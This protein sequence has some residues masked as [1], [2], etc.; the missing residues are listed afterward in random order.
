[1]AEE[2]EFPGR[3]INLSGGSQDI[4]V[5]TPVG[6]GSDNGGSAKL[7]SD[8]L[9]AG[10]QTANSGLPN[11]SAASIPKGGRYDFYM[12]GRDMEEMYG[13]QQGSWQ[14]WGN[15]FGKMVGTATTSFLNG[16]V[17][18]VYG[19]GSMI[20][21]QRAASFYDNEFNR[22]LDAT[23]QELENYLPNFYTQAERDASWY[24]P[25]N[26]LT[27]NFFSDKVLK[28]LGYSIGSIGAGF[29]WGGIL[30]SIGL[31]NRLVQAG[32]GLETVEAVENAILTAPKIG[33]YGAVSN[34]LTGLSNQYLKPLASS[35]LTNADRG[36]TSA[37]GTMGE[38]SFESLQNLNAARDKMI[39]SYINKYG[40]AP[41]GDALNEINDYAEKVGNFTWGMNVALLTATNYIQLP[42][43]LN[44]SKVAERRAMNEITKDAIAEGATIGERVAVKYKKAAGVLES[45]AGNPGRLFNKYVAKP[46]GLF[47][48]PSEAFEEGAQFAIQ[49]GTDS[50]FSRAYD[51]NQDVSSFWENVAGAFQ[52]VLGEGVTKTLTTKEGLEGIL[53]GGLSGGLQTSFSPFGENT[54]KE[55]GFFGEGGFK[56][57]NTETALKAIN[58]SKNLNDVLKDGVKYANIAINSQKLRQEAIANNDTLNEK[59]YEQDYTLAY[60]MPRVKYGKLDSIKEEVGLYKQQALTE[61]GFQ[62][63]QNEGVVLQGETREQ[64]LQRIDN[65]SQ[66]ASQTNKMFEM[67]DDK[68]SVLVDKDGERLYGDDLIEKMTYA[69]AKIVNY[70]Q[71]TSELQGKLAGEGIFTST[72]DDALSNN[73]EWKAGDLKG[74]LNNKDVQ[75][76][77]LK[78]ASQVDTSESITKDEATEDLGDYI[79][80][81]IRRKDFLEEFNRMKSNPEEF[82][83]IEPI[84]TTPTPGEEKETITV[85]TQDGEE[86]IEIGT[87]YF[88]GRVVKKTDKDKD[89]YEAPKFTVLGEN[90]DG[91]IQIKTEKGIHNVSKERFASYKLGKV[92]DTLANRKAK[93]FLDHWNV[94]YQFNFG[95]DKGGKVNGRLKYSPKEGVLLFTYKNKKG[96]TKSIEVTG[97][98][99]VAKGNFKKPMIT[100]VMKL[101]AAQQKSLE[102]FAAEKDDRL[103][104]KR[105]ARL[106]VLNDLFEELSSSQKNTTALI[107]KKQEEIAKIKKELASLEEEIANA[108]IDKRAKNTVRFKSATKK[109]LQSA[110][111]LSRMQD[112]L[113]NEVLKLQSDQEEIEFNLEYVADLAQN[114]DLMPTDSA[115]FLEE[116]NDQVIDLE[117]LQEKTGKQITIVT[118][119]LKETEKALNSAIDFITNLIEKFENKYPDVPRAMGQDFVDFLKTNPNF[120]KLKPYYREELSELEDLIANVEEGDITVNESKLQEL[121]DH[122]NVIEGDLVELQKEIGAKQ[123]VLDRFQQVAEQYKQQQAEEAAIKRDQAV[124]GQLLGTLNQGVQNREYDKEYQAEPRKVKAIVNRST[125]APSAKSFEESG[126]EVSPHHKRANDFGARM[127][128]FSNRNKINGVVVTTNNQ[129]KIIPGLTEFLKQGRENVDSST[130]IALVMAIENKDGSFTPVN[131]NGEAIIKEAGETDEA[132]TERLHNEGIFQ[133]FPLKVDNLFSEDVSEEEVNTLDEQ[134][135]KFRKDALESTSLKGYEIQ[136]SF[137]I[138]QYVKPLN[139]EGKPERDYGAKVSVEDSGLIT[140]AQLGGSPVVYVPTQEEKIALGST[141]FSNALGRA[142][143]RLKNAYVPL[144]NRQ[145]TAKEANAIYDAL[146]R[147]ATIIVEEN[148][149][150]KFVLSDSPEATRLID[151]LR[152][153]TYWGTPRE[154]KNAGYNS[155]WFDKT[156]GGFK[157]FMSG[158]EVAVSEFTPTD[159]E[160]NK[161]LIT[162]VLQN[163]YANTNSRLTDDTFYGQRY[164]QIVSVT[165]EGDYQSVIWPNYQSYLL[166]NKLPDSNGKLT[167]ARN[168]EDIPLTTNIAPVKSGEVNRVGIYFTINDKNFDKQYTDIAPEGEAIVIKK[169]GTPVQPAKVVVVPTVAGKFKLNG[170]SVNTIPLEK[171]GGDIKFIYDPANPGQLKSL[172]IDPTILDNYKPTIKQE[173][174]DKYISDRAAEE[175]I[176]EDDARDRIAKSALASYVLKQVNDD[177]AAVKQAEEDALAKAIEEAPVVSDKPV[178]NIYWGSPESSTNTKLLSNLAPRKFT[179]QDKEYGSVEH[180]YQTLKSG[181]FDQVTYDKY[182]KAGGY[183]TKI[184]GKAVQQGFDNLQ[185]MKDLVVES[186]KQNPE[187]AKLLL[188]YSDFTHTTNEVIDKA[189][190]DGIKLAQKNA[191]LSVLET[192]PTA[193][194]VQ[195]EVP[196]VDEQLEEAWD[197]TEGVADDPELREMVTKTMDQFEGEDWNKIEEFLKK[198]LPA[199][200][201]VYRVK[202]VLRSTNGKQAWGMFSNG[203]IYVYENAEVGTAYHEVFEAVW[204]MFTD[205]KEQAAILQ[206]FKNRP[207]TY[208]DRVTGNTIKYS[209]ATPQQAKEELAE[210]FRAFV[211]DGVLPAKNKEGQSLI[212]KLF[213]E[214]VDFIKNFFTGTSA[215]DNTKELFERIGSGYYKTFVPQES[216]LSYAKAGIIDIE[217]AQIILG[218]E[219]SEIPGLTNAQ[220]HEIMQQMTFLTL[221]YLQRDNESLFNVRSIDKAKLYGRI[222]TNLRE[223]IKSLSNIAQ[224]N[225]KKDPSKQASADAETARYKALFNAILL[226]WDALLASHEVYLKKYDIEFDENDQVGLI[227]SNN[228][229]KGEYDSSD[230][231][232]HFRKLNSATKLV[233]S[234]LPV[235]GE[236]GEPKTTSIG[237]VE[238]IPLSESWIS[239]MNNIHDALS[240]DDMVERVRDMAKEDPNYERLFQRLTKVPSTNQ[241]DW[242]SLQKHD[243]QL[244]AAFSSAFDK[245]NPEVK[246]LNILP[247]NGIQVGDSNLNTAT[248]QIESRFVNALKSM[249][250][251]SKNPYFEYSSKEKAYIAKPG[252]FDK[253]NIDTLQGK[254]KF[255]ASIGIEFNATDIKNLEV[256]NGNLYEKFN[257]ATIGIKSSMVERKKLATIGGKTLDINKRLLTLAGI[258]ARIEN[259]EFSSTFYGVN[260][261]KSQ[262][263]IGTNPSSDLYKNLSSFPTYESLKDSPQYSYLYTDSFAQNSVL[264]NQI[265]DIDPVTKTGQRRTGSNIAQ[266]L[267]PAAADGTLDQSKGKKKSSSSLTFKERLVQEINMNLDGFYYNLVAGDAS[268]EYMT[269]MG[270][271]ITKEDMRIGYDQIHKVFKGYLIDEINLVREK[272]PV[273]KDR[274]TNELRFMK[275]VLGEELSKTVLADKDS[276][277]EAIYEANKS[278]IDSAVEKFIKNETDK[279]QKTLEKYKIVE[280]LGENEGYEVSNLSL[281]ESGRISAENLELALSTVTANYVINNIEFH[282]VLYSDPYQYSDELKRIKNFLSPRQAIINNSPKMNSVLNRVWNEGYDKD[283]IGNTDFT[284]DYFT[285]TT[286]EDVQG[287]IDL[288]NYEPWD[289]ADGS[290]IISMKAHRN[291]RIR[292]S[293][294][295]D[296]EERQYRYD[297]AYEKQ[298]KELKLSPEETQLLKDGNPGITS[299]YTP[300]KPIVAGNKG[301][302]RSY[303]DIMLDKLAL[304]PLSYRIQKEIAK[305]GGRNTSNAIALY[306]KMAAEK[307]DYVVFNTARKV[308]A[309]KPNPPYNTDGSLNTNPYKGVIKVPFA[310]ISIQSEVPSKEEAFVT[311]GSQVTK[312]LTLDFMAAGVPVDFK[313]NN[314]TE[315]TT[316]RYEAWYALKTE[317]EREEASPLYKEI[318]D[319]QNLLEEMT[320]VGYQTFLDKLGIEEKD[321]EFTIVDKSKA[322]TTLRNEILKREVNS[323]IIAAL[324]DFL[325]GDS[326][327]EATPAYQQI[328]NILY[329]LADK[330]VISPKISGG[331]KVQIPSTF[332][333]ETRSALT[334]ING[335]KGYTSDILN[336]YEKDGKRVAEI[337]VGRWFKSDKTDEELLDLW[338]KKDENGNR[339]NDLTEEGEKVLSGLAFRIPTQKQNSIDSIV[340]KQFLP[341][342]FGDSVIIPSALVRK[343]GSDFDIDKLSIYLKNLYTNAKGELK[344]VPYFGIGQEAK[345]KIKDLMVKEDI[346]YVLLGEKNKNLDKVEDDYDV[347]ADRLYKQSLENAYIESAQNLVS[348]QENYGQ[349]IKPNSADQLKNLANK[350]SDKLGIEKPDYSSVGNMLDRTFMDSL[351]HAFVTGKY[352]IGIAAIAQT[353]HSLNQR[354]N[355]YIDSSKFNALTREDK[356]WLTG[357]TMKVEDLNIRFKDFNK[358]SV[359]GKEV[360][361]LSMIKNTDG[362]YISDVIG[363]FIDGYVD[364]AKD[365]WI[366]RLGAKPN[367]ASTFLFLA[368]IGIPIDTVAYFMNQPI[369]LDYLQRIENAGYSYLFIDSFVEDTQLDYPTIDFTPTEIAS[370]SALL[371]MVGKK[372]LTSEENAQQQLILTEFLKYAKMAEQLL[373]VTQGTNY[374]TASL[375]DSSLVYKKEQQLEKAKKSI[376]SS[377]DKLL[378]N[379][380]IGKLRERI[381]KVR[382]ALGDTILT[383]DKG[384][385]RQVMERVLLPY[386]DG[387]NDREFLKIATKAKND[388]FDWAV[389]LTDSR[390]KFITSLLLSDNNAPKEVM[391]FKDEIAQDPSHQ[392][393]DN[394]IV[395][396]KGIL[397]MQSADR[398]GRANNLSLA[399]TGNKIYD[400]DQIIYSFK[401]LKKYLEGVNKLN[402]YKK[403]VGVSILQSGLSNTPY[404]F[405]SLL[406]YEDFKEVYGDV[407][408]NLESQTDIDL[409][410]YNKLNVFQRNNWSDDTITPY[411]KARGGISKSGNPYY[412]LSMAFFNEAARNAM[413]TGKIPQ[414]LKLSTRSRSSNKDVVV[415]TWEKNISKKEK[416]EMRKNGDYS[417]INKGLFVKVYKDDD[418]TDPVI[419]K[420]GEYE[421]YLYKMVNAWGD[422][423][424]ANEFYS[425]EQPSVIDNGFIPVKEGSYI[426][427]DRFGGEVF[428]T[429]ILTSPEKTDEQI[430]RYLQKESVSSQEEPLSEKDWTTENNESE[431]PLDC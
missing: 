320:D 407:I 123:L 135:K 349:L 393:Y 328:R 200:I 204:K 110:M 95:K 219:L 20:R 333:E 47:F 133:T 128:S 385:I 271:H 411:E 57:T 19:I 68:Y 4:P 226:N 337:M 227:D 421:N 39:E 83:T 267:K 262:T 253:V 386:T 177:I 16:T 48:A 326:V 405:T 300:S 74:A 232:D 366:M 231:I 347:I 350:I 160:A 70:D 18:T 362:E 158:K 21:D 64:F 46:A 272:R 239:V 273:A 297:V 341:K 143:L 291:L 241:V 26:I 400:Q 318:K 32:K 404:S 50:Y 243:V 215:L 99:F 17:G 117:V 259:P 118:S 176:S 287:I 276:A 336:F 23:N 2:K 28:N 383:S 284:Q 282:K 116:L 288:E 345:Q 167:L 113:E 88:I 388:F 63:L 374:D 395:G 136:A 307:L 269:Y 192:K 43:L 189:F 24:S 338:Y 201:P 247:N 119:L 127:D 8:D 78:L 425:I 324:G 93:F 249:F 281:A 235:I 303:N 154:G 153:V 280:K 209:E 416:E 89:I 101:Q 301:N 266:L 146:Q 390:N 339:T 396:K 193:P 137:G 344:I 84:K 367:V 268:R 53:I 270:N 331:L 150:G 237:G 369:V 98:Q 415:Y 343:V 173:I 30:K 198:V 195:E 126:E 335:K 392:L 22:S 109:A 302:G 58:D 414:L 191:E 151:W 45:I 260:G 141:S 370:K 424:R 31:T 155:V 224:D 35:I 65:I 355:T 389:Q 41:T 261:E 221:G 33:R 104:A 401:E 306:N 82:K 25:D 12:P 408:N 365:P 208:E 332:L 277:P 162:S 394:Q 125:I 34:A 412:N 245:Q 285:S 384:R 422:G 251:D 220:T 431:N 169:E 130:T 66:T 36:L 257:V 368:K 413:D 172:E 310:I 149:K 218:S 233:L 196:A 317:K 37:F 164:E 129:E 182:V 248:R 250:N 55:R 121:N 423:F 178:I 252:A 316:K 430:R 325:Q 1:M 67:F 283:D 359:D 156:E 13:Q 294:W 6:P 3:P 304:Y 214:L 147:L 348:S 240:A 144:N 168:S 217:N 315:F 242:D 381:N 120:L 197:A 179:Y 278:R 323:N 417:F 91:T 319:N 190:L 286:L 403:I 342:E 175:T 27:A 106:K 322:A 203:A 132:F 49:T 426:K 124:I 194:V 174:V 373:N 292:S 360:A 274:K 87:E 314:S 410:T 71:R 81:T 357:G 229:G 321:G 289:E 85:K 327:L 211:K 418:K 145:H 61:T 108:E 354:Q 29:A 59:D 387:V 254:I 377:A 305:N 236:N 122:L 428:K 358:L 138:P 427:E 340:I 86:E 299:A 356:Y 312:L 311:R 72:L 42:K 199:N 364:I 171:L 372:D 238:L 102:D 334:E 105:A 382:N 11:V 76:A 290:G 353:N 62:E 222:Q 96:E 165:P 346:E 213:N 100:P 399:N 308:G 115:D 230:K 206:E 352:A 223:K 375:N 398:K 69:S 79:D 152:T 279:L 406:P 103:E 309:E 166:S 51:T 75:D 112:Q 131:E 159:L 202:N 142:F 216:A 186:F 361:T 56:G 258:K 234:T 73:P 80:L 379:S 295:N 139:S 54:I 163:M 185:L 330:Y 183:G 184:R 107:T 397:N 148:K 161:G 38:A 207:G 210:E 351:R 378:N 5:Y 14:K 212:A 15:G 52:N 77:I 313:H 170:E 9:Y 264:L 246:I 187:Q 275:S 420:S 371:K 256:T 140:Q 298:D 380:Y 409:M 188:N 363:Q 225:A 180:A 111:R 157:L 265:F 296:N 429:V 402:L 255:L 60:I 228:T 94:I 134:Y 391:T 97:D 244:L 40:E 263:Y 44:S 10:I 92:S 7:S 376:I 329:S 205:A 293:N 181:S 419:I 90:E 114:I